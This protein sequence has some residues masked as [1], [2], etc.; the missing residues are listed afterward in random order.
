VKIT[1]K[2]GKFKDRQSLLLQFY[3][4][5]GL[6]T[7][8]L[9]N[10]NLSCED[11]IAPDEFLNALKQQ[12]FSIASGVPCS[13]FKDLLTSLE[14]DN[15]IKYIPATRE[16]EA[17]GI[18]CGSYFGGK[19]GIVV[20]QNSGFAVIGD[21]LTSLAQLYEIPMLILVSWRGLEPDKDSPEHSIMGEV[22]EN[23]LEAYHIPYWELKETDWQR[24]LEI[25]LSVMNEQSLPV[26]L[27]VKTGV[28]GG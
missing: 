4:K 15:E 11:M 13:Y 9:K 14:T 21:A 12:G 20:M 25:A 17:I 28:F 7:V 10:N 23:V 1:K 8:K 6:L 19:T 26:C 16:D 3:S 24:T 2:N 22:T 5:Y 18:V 27:I